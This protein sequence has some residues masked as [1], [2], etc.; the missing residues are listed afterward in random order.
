MGCAPPPGSC[1][2]TCSPHVVQS[3]I[4]GPRTRC[5]DQQPANADRTCFVPGSWE[6]PGRRGRPRRTTWSG[7]G[8]PRSAR[9]YPAAVPSPVGADPAV[10]GPYL[11]AALGEDKWREPSVELI[12]AGMSNLTYVV[13]PQGAAD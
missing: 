1:A 5:V 2:G 9:G 6:S 3:W 4:A 12:T 8:G 10:V 7:A 13:T 11:A